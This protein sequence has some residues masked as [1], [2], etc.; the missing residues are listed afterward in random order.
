MRACAAEKE[1]PHVFTFVVRT[2][3]RALREDWLE[4][5]SAAH[6]GIEIGL[7]IERRHDAPGDD[8]LA[9]VR[10]KAGNLERREDG[11]GV[12]ILHGLPVLAAEQVWHGREDVETFATRWREVRVAAGGRVQI[13]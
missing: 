2:E 6:V 8:M 11:V 9:H 1:A 3:P 4:L 5:E 7:E 13:E 10:A 12:P